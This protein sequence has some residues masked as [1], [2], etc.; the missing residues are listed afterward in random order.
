MGIISY[1]LLAYLATAVLALAI[2]GIIVVISKMTNKPEE[3]G[4]DN[5]G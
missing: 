2:T 3:A 4:E 5:D 1:A